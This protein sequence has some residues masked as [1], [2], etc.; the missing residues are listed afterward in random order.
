LDF[1]FPIFCCVGGTSVIHIAN[2]NGRRCHV[3]GIIGETFSFR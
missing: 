2:T 1:S 3:S